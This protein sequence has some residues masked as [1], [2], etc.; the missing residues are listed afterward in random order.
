MS[1]LKLRLS[2]L[3]KYLN[4]YYKIS[5]DYWAI[6][7]KIQTGRF[8]EILRFA[9]L[10][11]GYFGQNNAL[12]LQIPWNYV[13]PLANSKAIWK[14]YFFFSRLEKFPHTHTHIYISHL[15]CG[16]FPRAFSDVLSHHRVGV[17]FT[18]VQ[19]G[20]SDVKKML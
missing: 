7:E 9:T 11:Y 14:S 15:G 18:L 2:P 5:N 13:T 12:P 19:I 10:S 20:L 16:G 8:E 4:Y 6:P 17:C 1:S 3:C